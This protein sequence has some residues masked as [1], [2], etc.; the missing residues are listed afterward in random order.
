MILM[1]ADSV[2]LQRGAVS[3]LLH[4]QAEEP[5][6]VRSPRLLIE[7][8]PSYLPHT[9]SCL[10]HP[11]P[12]E[13]SRRGEMEPMPHIWDNKIKKMDKV[14][15]MHNINYIRIQIHVR[16]LKESDQLEDLGVD[17]RIILIWTLG[18]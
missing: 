9:R 5:P 4:Q 13:A 10:H 2:S 1:N 17:G 6:L 3:F 16:N 11:L 14:R 15:S 7:Y 12:E 8:I 18:N